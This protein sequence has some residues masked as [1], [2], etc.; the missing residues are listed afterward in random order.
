VLAKVMNCE[1]D[2]IQHSIESIII[3]IIII[4]IANAAAS[5]MGTINSS[6]R[7]AATLYCLGT[8]FVSGIYI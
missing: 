1:N 7:M 6:D 2:K 3:I 4:I 8:G 5:D